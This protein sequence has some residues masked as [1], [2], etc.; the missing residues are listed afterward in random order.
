MVDLEKLASQYFDGK[1]SGKDL[2]QMVDGN[3]LTKS[4]R[5][6]VV[7]ISEKLK[8]NQHAG[9]K[10]EMTPRQKLR[11]Q[12]KEKKSL[13]KLSKEDRRKKFQKDLDSQREKESANF[14]VC[15]G[16]KKRGHFVKNCPKLDMCLPTVVESSD[17]VCFNCGSR[18]HTLKN[19]DKERRDM[20]TKSSKYD[21]NNGPTLLPYAVCFICK[22]VG[23]I[24]RDCPENANGLYPKG[25]CCHICLQKDHL[26][27]DCPERTE[28]D[29]LRSIFNISC[30][31][32]V[33]V[34]N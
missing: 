2:S 33:I 12:V 30:M 22:Q 14:T 10:K 13:P 31:Y 21:R 26:V 3:E 18:E 29:K 4:E 28:E 11:L 27:K 34:L 9:V 1:I 19:C 23:H 20:G 5:R 32:P 25:G 8:K 17:G 6:K 15:L 7:K 24:A 16:C